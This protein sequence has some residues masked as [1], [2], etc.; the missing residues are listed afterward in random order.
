MTDELTPQPQPP[1]KK[2]E[3]K[4]TSASGNNRGAN[5]RNVSNTS[6]VKAGGAPVQ[7]PR[8]S[9][10]TSN[11]SKKVGGGPESGSEPTARRSTDTGKKL[12]QQRRQSQ[13][14]NSRGQS[15]RKS[16]ASA[17]QGGRHNPPK[18][19]IVTK[20]TSQSSPQAT[21]ASDAL[22][23]LQRVIADL[24]TTSPVQQPANHNGFAMAQTQAAP[25]LPS[26][27]PVFQPSS[28]F[29]P[30]FKHRKAASLNAGNLSGNFN[31]FSPHLGSMIE[32][33]E[34]ATG[35]NS[36]EEGE[37]PDYRRQAG[38]QLRSQS[39]SH[40]FTAPR[41]AALAAQQ[42]QVD[43][44]GPT[45]RPQLAPGFMFGARK[46]TIGSAGPPISEE[47]VGFQFPQQQQQPSY[48]FPHDSSRPAHRKSESGEITGIMAEQ[49]FVRRKLS[50]YP[51]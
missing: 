45:G 29:T 9:S 47:D 48:D 38:H 39:Q 11:G 18:E 27:V 41:F 31:S 8:P 42:E 16:Q 28:T 50:S 12:G 37:I 26:N 15:H 2:E 30:D 24:K 13:S 5:K 34:D 43:S 20:Q 33:A 36:F 32:D 4:S 14:S 49:V 25:S 3:K 10:R 7:G 46:R 51:D 22:S 17:S 23:S 40:N 21:E 35:N 6:G 19:Q 44:V 1:L